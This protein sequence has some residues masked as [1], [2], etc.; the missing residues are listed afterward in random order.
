V[1]DHGTSLVLLGRLESNDAE[2]E[3]VIGQQQRRRLVE[4]AQAL[5]IRALVRAGAFK[6]GGGSGTIPWSDGQELRWSV[7]DPAIAVGGLVVEYPGPDGFITDHL[8][9]TSTRRGFGWRRHLLCPGLGRE[10]CG[11]AVDL[12]HVPAGDARLACRACHGLRYRVNTEHATLRERYR[13]D[14]HALTVART[15]AEA[16]LSNEVF[17]GIGMSRSG[18]RRLQAVMHVLEERASAEGCEAAPELVDLLAAVARRRHAEVDPLAARLRS[19][20]GKGTDHILGI[21]AEDEIVEHLLGDV[22]AENVEHLVPDPVGRLVTLWAAAHLARARRLPKLLAFLDAL[23]DRLLSPQA[24]AAAEGLED[25]AR[26]A[27]A[28]R[29]ALSVETMLLASE[30][31]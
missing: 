9:L 23:H 12:L 1:L 22:S 3:I 21:E 13:E 15:K 2:V 29:E 30:C 18:A 7:P 8:D 16:D 24:V 5:D 26:L 10:G 14:P 6:P 25:L 4:D 31:R 28:A 11:A 27:S 19:L 17:Q 20:V